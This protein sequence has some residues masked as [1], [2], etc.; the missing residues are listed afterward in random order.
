MLLTKEDVK[1]S[2]QD[3]NGWELTGDV[4]ITKEF[5]FSTFPKAV[6]FVNQIADIAESRQHHP[7]ITLDYSTVK[8]ALSTHDEGGLTQKDFDSAH[9]YDK[10]FD[11]T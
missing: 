11:K 10:T 9:A 5:N 7:H 2:L 8:L 6:Q 1:A 3:S 4:W